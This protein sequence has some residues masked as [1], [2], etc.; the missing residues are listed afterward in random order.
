M[1]I[2]KKRLAETPEPKPSEPKPCDHKWTE[3]RVDG[4][5]CWY[6]DFDI[7]GKWV[8]YSI[9]EPYV[10]I[11]CKQRKDVVLEGPREI[12][13]KSNADTWGVI[14]ELGKQYK[15]IKDRAIV[16]DAINDLQLVDREYLRIAAIVMGVKL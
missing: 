2:F 9:V 8:R 1:G 14:E 12:L 11:H 6:I 13:C 5:E 10:C 7:E 4:E 15:Q 16:E 3:I